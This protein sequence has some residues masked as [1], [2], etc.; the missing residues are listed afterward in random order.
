MRAWHRPSILPRSPRRRWLTVEAVLWLA[1][2][3]SPWRDLPVVFGK[4]Y[5][6]HTRFQRWQKRG[7]WRK[8]WQFLQREEFAVATNLFIDS[9]TVRAHQHT[10]GAPK[11]IVATKLWDTLVAG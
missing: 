6:V 3:G 4:W 11:K 5:A 1:R 7:V 10:A 9:T 2:T 8:L